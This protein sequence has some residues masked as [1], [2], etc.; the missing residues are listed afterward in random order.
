M[1][2]AELRRWPLTPV[3]HLSQTSP[4]DAESDS[5]D[6]EWE[7]HCDDLGIGQAT[8]EVAC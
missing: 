1:I 7:P 8:N 4:G 5:E 6:E 3:L 2:L